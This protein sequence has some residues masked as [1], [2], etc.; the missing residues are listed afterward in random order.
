MSFYTIVYFLCQNTVHYDFQTT[1][2]VKVSGD[3]FTE[4]SV[5]SFL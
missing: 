5:K 3:L 1:D 2:I 4:L